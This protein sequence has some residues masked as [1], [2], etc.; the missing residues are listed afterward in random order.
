ML[1]VSRLSAILLLKLSAMGVALLDSYLK[2]RC[3]KSVTISSGSDREILTERL[4]LIATFITSHFSP[5]A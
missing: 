3:T 4:I 1:G 2:K 5:D